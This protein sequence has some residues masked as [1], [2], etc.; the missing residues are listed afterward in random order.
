MGDRGLRE[1]GIDEPMTVGKRI[2]LMRTEML[3][4][5]Q[6]ALGKMVGVSAMAVSKW[7]RD[8]NDVNEHHLRVLADATGLTYEWFVSGKPVSD[9]NRDVGLLLEM[10]SDDVILALF[11]VLLNTYFDEAKGRYFDGFADMPPAVDK[12]G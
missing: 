7:E 12:G 6:A 9:N 8:A 3:K 1:N 10:V 11:K 4:V 5:E 2:K